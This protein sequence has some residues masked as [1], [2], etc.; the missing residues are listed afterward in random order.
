MKR[1]VPFA[2]LAFLVIL[3]FIYPSIQVVNSNGKIDAA[4]TAWMLS[5]TGLVLI[6]TPGLAFFYGGMVN[7]KNVI[8]TMFQSFICMAVITVIWIT[9][10]FS[11]AFGNSIH[12]IIGDPRTFFMMKGM[13]GNQVWKLAPTIPLLLFAMYQLKFAIITPA[14]ITGAFAERIRFNSYVVFICLFFVCIYA[15]LAHCTWHP[16]GLLF[17]LGVLDFAGGTV[18]HMS[19]GWAALA[20]ALYL[21][22]RNEPNHSPARITYVMIGTGLLWFGWFGFNAG[23]AMGANPLAVTALATSTTASAA[24]AVCWI[25][26]DL[27][28]GKKPS[29]M[30]AC[31]GAV[32]GLVA[33]TPA[34]GFVS[35]PHSLAIGVISSLV[36]NLVVEWRTR[37][38][39]DDTLDVFPCH[40]VGGMV[41]MVLTGVF[42]HKNINGGNTT[43]N[44]LFF[45]EW[46]LFLTQL[47]ALVGVSIFAF[48]GSL[49][50]LKITDM[51]T[52]LRVS[53]EEEAIGLD[54][55][56][57]GEKL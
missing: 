39:I 45:G 33:I 35:I 26:V 48:F 1:Y 51:I 24:A 29:A 50:L 46:H 36:S 17:K 22:R 16:D 25:N 20:S 42:A 40:G 2:I 18:V 9:F 19:A 3:T 37:T 38:T 47:E 31:I 23:S 28:R 21:K 57:H 13:L 15:P 27:L 10:G 12:G 34:A 7:K 54:I 56:Q 6:M 49:L 8:S 43:G 14:L 41:G 44:G 53:A 5:A 4:D 52:P 30:G 32:V 55:S 11:L